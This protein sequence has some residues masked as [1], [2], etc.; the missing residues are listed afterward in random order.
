[1]RLRMFARPWSG[2]VRWSK[3]STQLTGDDDVRY[4]IHKRILDHKDTFSAL[5]R[6]VVITEVH[7]V[8]N[9]A[10]Q[11][12]EFRCFLNAVVLANGRL[13]GTTTRGYDPD[14]RLKL[15]RQRQSY[16]GEDEMGDKIK[17][18]TERVRVVLRPHMRMPGEAD[19]DA[20]PPRRKAGL[21]RFI[22][23]RR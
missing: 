20:P 10:R 12:R 23:C 21:V 2:P 15:E 5:D 4:A 3:D 8:K 6:A 13:G 11:I 16:P 19:P 18:A 14:I 22:R 7:F 1:M 9:A 17:A